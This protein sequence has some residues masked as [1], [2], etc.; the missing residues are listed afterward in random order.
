MLHLFQSNRIETL[1][2]LLAEALA[3]PLR[4]PFRPETV[5]VQNQGMERWLE[6]YLARRLSVCANVEFPLPASFAWQLMRS[7]LGDLPRRSL[8]SPE[9][10]AWRV[11]GWLERAERVAEFP[12][13]QSYLA[14]GGGY[15]R[16]ELACRIAEAFDQ[17]LVYRPDWIAR[18]EGGGW[19]GLG[20]DESWQ[21]ALWRDLAQEAGGRHWAHLMGQLLQRLD[22]AGQNNLP[23]RVVLFGISSLSPLFLEMVAKLARHTEVHVFALNPSQE[24]WE[25]IRDRKE[26]ARL[27]GE[28]GGDELF[29]ETGNPLLASLGKQGRDFFGA[30]AAFPELEDVFVASD[31]NGGTSLLHRLQGDILKLADPEAADFVPHEI[32]EG[33][34][35]LQIHS[36]HGAMREVEVL[37]DQLL[38]LFAA[39]P[40]L[41]PGEVAVLCPDIS[42]YAPY[43]DAVFAPSAGKPFIPYSIAGQGG[44]GALIAAFLALLDLPASRFNADWVLG[45]LEQPALLRRFGLEEGDLPLIHRWVRETGIRWGRDAAH[46]AE[47]GL[48]ATPRHTWRDGLERLLLGYALPQEAAG[49]ALPLY[50]NTLPYDDVEGSQ[51][52]VAGCF[53]EFAETLFEFAAMLKGERPLGR[54]AEVLSGLVERLFAPDA[55]EEILVRRVRDKL[56]LLRE[57]GEA[58]RFAQPVALAVVKSWLAGQLEQDAG[59]GGLF[60]GGV[61]FAGMAPMRGLPFRVICLLGLNDGAFPRRQTPTGFDLIAAHPRPGD[62]SRRLDDRYLFL[63][64]LLSARDGLYL[65]YVGQ[66]IRDNRELPPSVLVAELLDTVG[67]SC[68]AETARSIV[69]RHFLQPFSPGYFQGA[70]T[71]PAFSRSWLAASRE[72]GAGAV[73]P[74]LF[75]AP[76][77]EPEEEWHSVEFERLAAFY[78]N[79]ARYLLQQRLNLRLEEGDADF[80]VREPF[81]LDYFTRQEVRGQVLDNLRAG[82]PREDALLLAEAHGW[83]PHGDYGARLLAHE[84]GV[85]ERL[86]AQLQAQRTLAPLPLNFAAHGMRLV[87]WLADV[88]DDGLVE[89]TLDEVKPRRLFALWLRHLVLCLVRPPGAALRSRLIGTDRSVAFGAVV[90][91]EEELAK[92][93]DHYRQGLRSPLPFFVKSAHAYAAKIHAGKGEEEALKAAHLAWDEPEQRNGDFRG[94]SEN[95]YYRAVYRGHDPLDERFRA[96][97]ADLLLPML[98]AAAPGEGA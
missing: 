48:P 73:L 17:Y 45:L 44:A 67:A 49:G 51:A 6:L 80:E 63:E 36:C 75:D 91:P 86:A 50:G 41:S 92:L 69:T 12:R 85:A 76:L 20:S 56:A 24:Y 11:M 62:R 83:L 35:S 82:R 90:Q 59:S 40:G 77:P 19:C 61:A 89:Y 94:E 23:Q 4:S 13:L 58:A 33:D 39:D 15:R 30:L 8:F 87:G 65:S 81:A 72:L 26:Q 7:L 28:A 84:E 95:G 64:T 54:W 38:R 3:R 25:L 14:G 29:L 37:H 21:A 88:G 5:M 9:I 10:L 96:V 52:Q 42:A 60:G 18:W 70:A 93:L 27:A 68:G 57:L 22:G 97:A 71:Y 74:P 46:K 98:Q 47:L 34:R 2:G 43:I 1:A 78:N 53:A 79:P 32:A 31:E 16:Y 55:E 66:D